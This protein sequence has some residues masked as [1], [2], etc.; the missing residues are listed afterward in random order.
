MNQQLQDFARKTILDGLNQLPVD[1]QN[2]YKLI[3]GRKNGKKTVEDTLIVPIEIIVAETPEDKLD[4]AMQQIEE[5]LKKF[6][7]INNEK[8]IL[9]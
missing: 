8:T 1:W 5:S 7:I 9:V 4:W 2:K 6:K 3:Y